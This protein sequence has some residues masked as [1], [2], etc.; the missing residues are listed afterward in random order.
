MLAAGLFCISTGRTGTLI[1]TMAYAEKTEQDWCAASDT[2]LMLGNVDMFYCPD[3]LHPE[4]IY[5]Y[6]ITKVRR[7][8]HHI[9]GQ[10]DEDAKVAP[11]LDAMLGM[12]TNFQAALAAASQDG[13]VALSEREL[14]ALAGEFISK[15]RGPVTKLVRDYDL[16]VQNRYLAEMIVQTA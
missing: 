1:G 3:L 9:M 14:A 11:V 8:L 6:V 15:M 12:C 10:L 13:A 4:E 2:I 7:R 5:Q 16:Y